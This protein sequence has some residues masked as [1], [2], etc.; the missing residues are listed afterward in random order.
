M[1]YQVAL[2]FIKNNETLPHNSL[3]ELPGFWKSHLLKIE[4]AWNLHPQIESQMG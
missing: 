3:L 1:I 4:R 2:L